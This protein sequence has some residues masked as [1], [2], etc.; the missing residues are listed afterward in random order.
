MTPIAPQV[1]RI[2]LCI[3]SGVR[4]GAGVEPETARMGRPAR[5]RLFVLMR[6][7]TWI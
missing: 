1:V 2:A 7:S 4:I 6:E 5:S 3:L